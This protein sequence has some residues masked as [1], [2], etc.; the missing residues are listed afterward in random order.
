M[1]FTDF[2]VKTP[3]K[4]S[5][6]DDWKKELNDKRRNQIQSAIDGIQSLGDAAKIISF[7]NFRVLGD[8][9]YTVHHDVKEFVDEEPEIFKGLVNKLVG[10]IVDE[11][12]MAKFIK[13]FFYTLVFDEVLHQKEK[14]FVDF[15]VKNLKVEDTD[16]V[17]MHEDIKHFPKA[18]KILTM[19]IRRDP[20]LVETA[21][22]QM[23]SA[24]P[25]S[26]V[27]F[28][29]NPTRSKGWFDGR[30]VIDVADGFVSA[31]Y[32][33]SLITYIFDEIDGDTLARDTLL[34][35][36]QYKSFARSLKN[37]I[38]K[39]LTITEANLYTEDYSI[40]LNS[41][42]L[43]EFF[44]VLRDFVCLLEDSYS[45]GQQIF[46]WFYR[47][48]RHG[49]MHKEKNEFLQV[50]MD[51]FSKSNIGTFTDLTPIFDDGHKLSELS[52]YD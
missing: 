36:P 41:H 2:L 39:M 32:R 14:E 15:F 13:G 10:L 3:I 28:D 46:A 31:I 42:A 7:G 6:H 35:S 47:L 20:E 33:I 1:K 21:I 29:F 4:E 49:Q 5:S 24:I 37:E 9:G 40:F 23:I 50:F 30:K 19:I 48:P 34:K 16:L 12:S 43:P 38:K 22:K 26:H 17:F 25:T 11:D 52:Y 18:K 45:I 27:K 51:V 8:D 44:R